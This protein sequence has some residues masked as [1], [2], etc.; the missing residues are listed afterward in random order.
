MCFDRL[1]YCTLVTWKASHAGVD[2]PGQQ[3]GQRMPPDGLAALLG[4]VFTAAVFG[5]FGGCS[6]G[7]AHLLFSYAKRVALKQGSNAKRIYN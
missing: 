3:G 2:M 4:F 6:D 7:T 1:Q 5:T